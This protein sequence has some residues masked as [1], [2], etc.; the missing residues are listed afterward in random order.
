MWDIWQ[1]MRLNENRRR[2]DSVE[3]DVRKSDGDLAD[4]RRQIDKI[5]LV[6]QALYELLRG[7]TGITD[8]DLRRK[9]REVDMRDGSEDGNIQASPLRCPKCSGVV[10][11]GALFCQTCGATVAPKYPYEQ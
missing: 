5:A 9:I 1:E 4:L 10:T 7:R 6:N 11:V 3:R 8:E 2:Q